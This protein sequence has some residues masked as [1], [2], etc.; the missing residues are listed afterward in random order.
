V[1]DQNRD[2]LD[3]PDLDKQDGLRRYAGPGRYNDS[4]MLEVGHGMTNPIAASISKRKL[5]ERAISGP[6]VSSAPRKRL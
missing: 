4:D 3:P 5:I 2:E 1:R 6:S